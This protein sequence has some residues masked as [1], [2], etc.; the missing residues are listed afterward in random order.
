M[1]SRI[2]RV[3]GGRAEIIHVETRLGIVNIHLGLT[4]SE[5][6]EVERVSMVPDRYAGERRVTVKGGRFVRETESERNDREANEPDKCGGCGA[7][8]TDGDAD[9]D[10]CPA[11]RNAAPVVW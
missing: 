7:A 5:G 2:K 8:Y 10:F 9:E 4:D 11:C 6:H 1:L 3:S